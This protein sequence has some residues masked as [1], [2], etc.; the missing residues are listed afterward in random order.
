MPVRIR[1]KNPGPE[2]RS[3]QTTNA[4]E[5]TRTSYPTNNQTASL[6][7]QGN[8]LPPTTNLYAVTQDSRFSDRLGNTTT[9]A[10]TTSNSKTAYEQRAKNQARTIR[11]TNAGATARRAGNTTNN[12]KTTHEQKVELSAVTKI[13]QTTVLGQTS[14]RTT[15]LVSTPTK[16]TRRTNLESAATKVR[17]TT[18]PDQTSRRTTN[19]VYTPTK[20]A[21]RTNLESAATKIAQTTD[22]DQTSKKT[23]D[24]D[25]SSNTIPLGFALPNES[26][27]ATQI[28]AGSLCLAYQSAYRLGHARHT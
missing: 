14:R 8:L 26:L 17:Q 18:D 4:H 1:S 20:T 5:S 27:P 22:P 21:R 25:C 11:T 12:S 24:L 13:T 23:T 28:S 3:P 7:L 2:R 6:Q 15:N 9:I 10:D 19:L 16:T